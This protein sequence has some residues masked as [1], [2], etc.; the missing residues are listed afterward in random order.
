MLLTKFEIL[1][2]A[3]FAGMTMAAIFAKNV[4][5]LIIAMP[6]LFCIHCS[7]IIQIIL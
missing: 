6:R 4:N 5:M 7:K 1:L 3:D 2:E